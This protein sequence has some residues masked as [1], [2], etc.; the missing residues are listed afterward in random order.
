MNIQFKKSKRKVQT[1]NGERVYKTYIDIEYSNHITEKELLYLIKDKY[2]IP[3]YC[4]LATLEAIQDICKRELQNGA[5]IRIPFLGS[6]RLKA[7]RARH[8]ISHDI[9]TNIQGKCL[10]INFLPD[11]SLRKTI[12]D[13]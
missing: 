9:P 2:K 12:K 7:I 1:T 8:E 3:H 11:K 6:L 10:S 4:V 13:S 5:I